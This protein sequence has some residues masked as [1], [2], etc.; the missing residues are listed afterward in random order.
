MPLLESPTAVLWL[1][2]GGELGL[3]LLRLPFVLLQ[4]G[5]VP[6]VSLPVSPACV[7]PVSPVLWHP[8]CPSTCAS[9]SPLLCPAVPSCLCHLFLVQPLCPRSGMSSLPTSDHSIP[10][11][12]AQIQLLMPCQATWGWDRLKIMESQ[13]LKLI[14][15][16]GQ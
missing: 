16:H 12:S 5:R 11:P 6:S 10:S 14:Q 13:T 15:F 7:P 8:C 9:P 3:C 1:G 4:G 2:R